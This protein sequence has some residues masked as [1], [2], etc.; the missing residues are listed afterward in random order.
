MIICSSYQSHQM[1]G[2]T[3]LIHTNGPDIKIQFLTPEIIRVRTSFDKV[4]A[5]ES[6]ILSSIGWGDRMD[7]LLGEERTHIKLVEPEVTE[8]EEIIHFVCL[9]SGLELR[10]EKQPFCISLLNSAGQVLHRD[11]AGRSF[12]LDS[13]NRRFHYSKVDGRDAFYGFGEKSG[14]LNKQRQYLRMGGKDAM[15]WN[16]DC[17]DPLYKHIPFY[18]KLDAKTGNA[19]GLYYNNTSESVFCMNTEVSSIERGYTYFQ[20]DAG[21]IDLFLLAGNK[22]DKVLDNYTFLTGRP[23]MLPKRALGYQ[24]S[25]MFYSELPRN[26]EDAVLGFV[27]TVHKEGYPLDGFYLSSGYTAQLDNK[28]CVFTWNHARYENPTRLFERLEQEGA[29]AVPNVKP[30]V[31]LCHPRY[32][33]FAQKDVFVHDANDKEP[34]VGIWWGGAGTFWDFTKPEARAAWKKN[35]KEMLLDLGARSLW[36]DNCEFDGILDK[37]AVC[38]FDGKKATIGEIRP[39]MPNLMNKIAVEAIKEAHPETRPYVLSRGGFAGIQKYA[40]TWCGDSVTSWEALRLNIA[41]ILGLSV[42]GV[43]NQ[44]T[45]IGGFVGNAPEPELWLRWIQSGIFQP[46]FC[47]HS[48]NQDFTTTE[49]WMYPETNELIREAFLLRYRFTPYLYSLEYRAHISGEPIMRPLVFDFQQDRKCWDEDV[50]FMF[51]SNILVANVVEKAAKT[52]KVY[53]PQGRRWYDYWT[54]QCYN[55]G[56]DIEIPVDWTSIPMFI[57]EGAV[58]PMAMN[59]IMNM[60]KDA[61]TALRIIVAP[62]DGATFELYDDDG[63]SNDYQKDICMKTTFRISVGEEVTIQVFKEGSYSD[64]VKN[65]LFEVIS[66]SSAP[67]SVVLEGKQIPRFLRRDL[68]EQAGEGW[69]YELSRRVVLI[70][71]QNPDSDYK[72][73]LNWDAGNILGM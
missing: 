63:V 58:I 60:E 56:Q 18:I 37:D 5:E 31:L 12:M 1:D 16:P 17:A 61:V 53:L 7:D 69:F 23:V 72:I 19:V 51:G 39:V 71:L 36:N 34:V 46:R 57:R 49:P 21:D 52:R 73:V 41:T 35:L 30:G 32:E 20:A 44:G 48:C 2:A 28:R 33:E 11:V 42:S 62:Q 45:D 59:Q 6:Y 4:F 25:G 8:S 50:E 15:A 14:R 3:C 22:M 70:K 38:D 67:H 29:P 65:L 24:G 68:F 47:I 43:P 9:Q 13:N 55:G 26:C 10:V 40:Q 54:Y 66:P 64:S 27:D